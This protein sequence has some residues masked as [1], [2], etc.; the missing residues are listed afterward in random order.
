MT[1]QETTIPGPLN[2]VV[3]I[4][5]DRIKGHL[6]RVVCGSVEDALNAPLDAQAD[7]LCNAQRYERSEVRRAPA[8]RHPM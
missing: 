6:D 3:R 8:H 4:D 5:G 1:I 2:N 7:R